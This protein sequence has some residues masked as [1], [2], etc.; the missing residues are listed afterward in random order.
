[1][2]ENGVLLLTTALKFGITILTIAVLGLL[3]P[4]YVTAYISINY[5]IVIIY[6]IAAMTLVYC[7]IS[8]IMFFVMRCR[9]AEDQM[10]LTN[11]S[12][13]EI[14]IAAAGA[15]GWMIV[16]G[17]GGTVSQRTIIDT[18]ERFGWLAACAGI[19][20]GLFL[21][22]G[23]LFFLNLWQT[24]ISDPDRKNKHSSQYSAGF[25]A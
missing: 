11:C 16:C 18:G 17:I 2:A 14:V 8:V 23:A 10:S 3:D 21:A 4:R 12:L 22:I 15:I 6:L 7:I 20:V 24:K 5:E 9:D 25:Q 13:F 19:S 1:M